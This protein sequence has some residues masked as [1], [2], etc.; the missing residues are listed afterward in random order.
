MPLPWQEVFFVE[1]GLRQM[2]WAIPS[3][4]R[5]YLSV[6]LSQTYLDAPHA[7]LP[8]E[9]LAILQP[10]DGGGGVASSCTVEA[11]CA[12]GWHSQ[13]FHIHTVWPSPVRGS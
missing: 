4:S 8:S 1:A 6:P 10:G 7:M 13:Q 2:I 11:N 9:F 5:P 3:I 12:G